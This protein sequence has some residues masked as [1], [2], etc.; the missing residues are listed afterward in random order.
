MGIALKYKEKKL[1]R[2]VFFFFFENI[3]QYMKTG[4]PV[5]N[6]RLVK[7]ATRLLVAI[8]VMSIYIYIYFERK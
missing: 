2:V 8:A 1:I 7:I 3:Q 6:R 5:N 4:C